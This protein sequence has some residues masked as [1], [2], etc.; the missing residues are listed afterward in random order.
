MEATAVAP[1]VDL[2]VAPMEDLEASEALEVDLM[3]ATAVAPTVDSVVAPT[4]D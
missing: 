2:V 3:E 1:I 4:E